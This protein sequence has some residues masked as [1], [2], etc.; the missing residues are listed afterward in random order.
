MI[1][2]G[3]GGATWSCWYCTSPEDLLLETAARQPARRF[4]CCRRSYPPVTLSTKPSSFRTR[5]SAHWSYQRPASWHKQHRE[6]RR[7]LRSPWPPKHNLAFNA[8]VEDQIRCSTRQAN[9]TLTRTTSVKSSTSTWRTS[10]TTTTNAPDGRKR[11]K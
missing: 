10:G 9:P 7:S 2:K 5:R 6:F 1:G 11:R 4:P 3:K 8:Q